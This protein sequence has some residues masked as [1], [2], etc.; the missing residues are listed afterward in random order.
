MN[1]ILPPVIDDIIVENGVPT[2]AFYI[3]I[4][5]ITEAVK[6]P[7]TG[8]GTPES[9]IV[10]TIGRWYVDTNASAGTGIYFK[11]TGEGNT[12]WILRS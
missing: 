11:Q 2:V 5:Q 12:G 7:L 4:Q 3:W 10:A 1:E 9:N 6:A 8:S